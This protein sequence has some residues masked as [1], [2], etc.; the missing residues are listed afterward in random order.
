MPRKRWTPQTEL[1]D[2]LVRLREKKKWQ[3]SYRRYVLEG[4]PS[5]AY[6]LYFGLDMKNLRDWFEAQFT[7]DLSWDNFGKAW[8]FEH[9]I[10]ATYFDFSNEND[11]RLCW[12][13]INIRVERLKTPGT[14]SHRIDLLAARPYFHHLFIRT[15]YALC[16]TMLEKLTTI[17]YFNDAETSN[18]ERFLIE[19]ISLLEKIA[20]LGQ[21]E[22]VKL[23]QGSTADDLLL[24]REILRKFSYAPKP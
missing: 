20:R 1:T 12:S 15:G 7:K 18:V 5:E 23:N 2:S 13:F 22:F 24:E 3:L 11:L 17:E 8:Q 4:A 16:E 21:E 10:P 6:A 14:E 19:N 9:I